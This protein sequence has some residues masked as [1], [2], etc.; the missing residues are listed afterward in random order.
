MAG[1]VAGQESP[2]LHRSRGVVR[3]EAAITTDASGVASET[4]IGVGYGRLV[5][6]YYNGGLDASA[7]VTLKDAKSGATIF[8]PYVTGTEGTPVTLHPTTNIVDNAGATVAAA[9]TATDVWRDIKV[10]GKLNLV[11]SAGGNAETGIF[12][13]VIDE[14]ERRGIGDIALTV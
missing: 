10:N 12:A 6:V 1:T 4:L 7:S 2:I 5:A 14:S 13:F 9:I 8:G 11:V 3:I